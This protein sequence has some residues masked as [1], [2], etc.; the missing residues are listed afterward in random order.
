MKALRNYAIN[1]KYT[2]AALFAI[3]VMVSMQIAENSQEFTL[4]WF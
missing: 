1:H 2:L 4:V 3:G